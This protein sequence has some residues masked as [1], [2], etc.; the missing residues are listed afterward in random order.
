MKYALKKRGWASR[1]MYE[2]KDEVL[3]VALK[4]EP[5]PGIFVQKMIL[6]DPFGNYVGHI[7]QKYFSAKPVF[8]IYH[9]KKYLA[10]VYRRR[11]LFWKAFVL[12]S[13]T[14]REYIIRG[15]YSDYEFIFYF[16]KKIAAKVSK[17]YFDWM[18]EYGIHLYDEENAYLLVAATIAL[19]MLHP[20]PLAE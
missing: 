9:E 17:E 4:V 15:D 7:K 14:G 3:E 6:H 20:A 18:K 1:K 13:K 12:I 8:H 10:K 2:V 16:K 11:W 19:D 5:S